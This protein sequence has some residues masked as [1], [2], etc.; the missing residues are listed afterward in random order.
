MK[1]QHGMPAICGL[2]LVGLVEEAFRVVF[3]T[4]RNK[5][6]ARTK[7]IEVELLSQELGAVLLLPDAEPFTVGSCDIELC[8]PVV[9]RANLKEHYENEKDCA[10]N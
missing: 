10:D 6:F 1:R 2:R 4:A 5:I 7:L 3:T 9:G 8:R